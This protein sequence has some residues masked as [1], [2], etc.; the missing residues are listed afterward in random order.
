MCFARTRHEPEVLL[1][2]CS[3]SV[4][5]QIYSLLQSV[6]YDIFFVAILF[7]K[8]RTEAHQ[9][10]PGKTFDLSEQTLPFVEEFG[11][12]MPGGFLIYRAEAPEELIYANRACI[13]IFGCDDLEDFKRHTGCT[14]I[15]YVRV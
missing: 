9:N 2:G 8:T 1:E 14:S 3:V 7:E 13:D 10:M 15:L 4:E 5:L 6:Q 12:R 11:D